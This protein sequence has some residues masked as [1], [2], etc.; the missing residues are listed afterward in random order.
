MPKFIPTTI[1]ELKIQRKSD[2]N[3]SWIYIYTSVEIIEK[4]FYKSM[5]ENPVK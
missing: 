3:V 5:Y 1:Q 4:R 2:P